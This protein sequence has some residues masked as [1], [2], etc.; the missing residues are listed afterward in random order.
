MNEGFSAGLNSCSDAGFP[1]LGTWAL[2][3]GSLS[4]GA[5]L[6]STV[7]YTAHGS[8]TAAL[9]DANGNPGTLSL[10]F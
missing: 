1:N 10:T 4:E 8:L 7:Y 6:G 5:T 3:I 2:T 9:V